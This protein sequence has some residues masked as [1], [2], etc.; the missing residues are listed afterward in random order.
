MSERIRLIIKPPGAYKEFM[1]L[2]SRLDWQLGST[3]EKGPNHPLRF[4]QVFVPSD[5]SATVHYVEDDLAGVPYVQITGPARE[6]T[7]TEI[8][9]SIPVYSR[10]ELFEAW[11]RAGDVD[12][13]VDAIL[14]LGVAAPTDPSEEFS[15]RLREALADEDPD[16]HSAA[17][18]AASY[19]CW[20]ELRPLVEKI[21]DAEPLTDAGKRAQIMLDG[22]DD[23]HAHNRAG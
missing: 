9:N 13:K 16:I 14:A 21:R 2:R 15:R 6:A 12:D 4:Q 3:T 17:L 23:V 7:A 10:E 22:W 5:R 11:D 18:V 20:D 1:A 8:A 19:N